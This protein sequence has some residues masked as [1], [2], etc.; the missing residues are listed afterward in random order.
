MK[1]LLKAKRGVLGLDTAKAVM[2]T[3]L[4]IS[5]VAIAI[6][7]ALSSLQD[8]DILTSGSEAANQTDAVLINVS[9]GISG[10]FS[11]AGT[12]LTLLAVVVII[13]IIAIVIVSVGRFGS[14]TQGL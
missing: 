12:W 14:R 13:L 6:I 1:K 5:V 7:I 10:F 11:N 8:A 9:Q 3:L 4:T 2:I